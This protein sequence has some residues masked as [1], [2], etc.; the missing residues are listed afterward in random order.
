MQSTKSN[1]TVEV[2]VKLEAFRT[3]IRRSGSAAEVA[4]RCGCGGREMDAEPNGID[5]RIIP[6]STRHRQFHGGSSGTL[7]VFRPG[8]SASQRVRSQE[9]EVPADEIDPLLHAGGR[10]ERVARGVLAVVDQLR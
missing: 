9:V 6:E 3:G 8:S 1:I 7:F 2:S 10:A 5:I 4:N